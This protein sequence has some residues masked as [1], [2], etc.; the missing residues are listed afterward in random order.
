[1]AMFNWSPCII[2]LQTDIFNSVA[3]PDPLLVRQKKPLENQDSQTYWS[4][5]WP[6]KHAHIFLYPVKHDAHVHYCTVAYTGRVTF[7]K[8][9]EQHGHD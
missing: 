7:Y 5:G 3:V 8:V 2:I 1:M 9:P 6:A 4:T